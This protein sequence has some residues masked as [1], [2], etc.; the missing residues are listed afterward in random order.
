M[1]TEAENPIDTALL[2]PP[3]TE[4]PPSGANGHRADPTAGKP[5]ATRVASEAPGGRESAPEDSV[6]PSGDR[7]ATSAGRHDSAYA[8]IL[9]EMDEDRRNLRRALGVA[10]VFHLGLFFVHLPDLMGPVEV[11]P[12][13][14]QK[15]YVVQQVRFQPPRAAPKRE[16]PDK[17]AK[18]IPIPDPTPHDPEPVRE[19]TEELPELDYDLPLGELNLEIPE[20]PPGPSLGEILQVG[21][22]VRRPIP[23]FAPNPGYTE[24]ARQ[25]RVQG[26]VILQLVIDKE[27]NVRDT[28][29]IKG[30]PMGLDEKAIET[31]KGW[32]YQ[33]A[34]KENGE[35]VSVYM[36]LT[37]NFSLQ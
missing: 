32:K 12:A 7:T 19:L 35:P 11:S 33:P 13:A 8:H 24:E 21:G 20:G 6:S 14:K 25:A 34:V 18:K 4:N 28:K 1:P 23:L 5:V 30:L 22:G 26:V 9:A 3:A 37:I 2:E 31:V 16:I 27:G 17:K 10:L 29:V 15:A 36:N